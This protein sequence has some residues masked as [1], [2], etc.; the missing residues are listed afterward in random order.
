MALRLTRRER[1]LV[2]DTVH[3]EATEVVRT[4]ASGPGLAVQSIPADHDSG[5]TVLSTAFPPDTGAVLVQQPNYLGVV[6]DLSS[7]ADAAHEVGALLVVS[8]DLGTLGVL[9]SPGKLGADI[10]VGDAQ[11]FGNAP[12]FGG[13][14]AGF[15]ACCSAHLRQLPGR[16]V[17][18]TVDSEGHTCY[19]LTLQAREQHIRRAKATS[20]ICSNQALSA[21]AATV[22][23]ALLGPQGL[24]ERGELCLQRAHHLQGS[25]CSLPGVH[26]YVDGP[27]F[28]EFALTLP[29]LATDFREAMRLRGVDPGVPLTLVGSETRAPTPHGIENAILVAVTDINTREALDKYVDVSRAVLTALAASSSS[30]DEGA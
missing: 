8:V 25:L 22:H 24:R 19:V 30:S 7:L 29:C 11:V 26:P 1:I 28:S 12:S 2:S 13:P 17:G 21:L 3:P 14:S 6:E 4:Y 20:N 10:V 27:F 16:V 15:L 23:L 5:R 18:Q 9:E